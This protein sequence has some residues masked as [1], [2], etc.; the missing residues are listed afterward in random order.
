MYKLLLQVAKGPMLQPAYGGCVLG[1]T[2][3]LCARV[4]FVEPPPNEAAEAALSGEIYNDMLSRYGASNGRQNALVVAQDPNGD[5]LGACGVYIKRRHSFAESDVPVLANLA[6]EPRAR[7][8]GIAKKLVGQCEDTVRGWGFKKLFT[9]CEEANLPAQRLYSKLGYKQLQVD[10]DR[11]IPRGTETFF[12]GSVQWLPTN[13]IVYEK[14][15]DGRFRMPSAWCRNVNNVFFFLR[16]CSLARGEQL[17]A[18]WQAGSAM[19]KEKEKKEKKRQG[20]TKRGMQLLARC[21]DII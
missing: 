1:P 16:G 12:G 17:G 11:K 18:A 13:L 14:S 9:F 20:R 7:R 3:R 21:I 8:R 6:V 10:V 15:L 4:L 2:A 19:L 5:L